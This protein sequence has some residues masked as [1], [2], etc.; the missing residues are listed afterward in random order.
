MIAENSDIIARTAQGDIHRL[1]IKVIQ[2]ALAEFAPTGDVVGE[3][4]DIDE[5][6]ERA[7]INTHNSLCHELRRA[8]AL[9]L[10]A[11]FERQLRFWLS[12]KMPADNKNGEEAKW[13]ELKK[14]VNRVDGSITANPVITDLENLGLVANVVRH[15]N[16]PSAKKLQ[17][18]PLFS[19]QTG[20]RPP[21][22][23]DLVGN[24]RIDDAQ[25]EL[26]VTAVMRFWH[27]AGA[28]SLP[29]QLV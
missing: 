13:S 3:T 25:L 22:K 10:G 11:L 12:E 29:G 20:T 24:M 6:F 8:F 23:R 7:Q 26:Y 1:Y 27:L 5:F 14:L 21:V 18:A 9:I 15:R 28:S 4:T 16:G 17:K 19:N 2:P